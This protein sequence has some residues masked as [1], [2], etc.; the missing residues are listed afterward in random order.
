L[1]VETSFELV[2]ELIGVDAVIVGPAGAAEITLILDTA[3]VM[4]TIVPSVAESV[5]L[6]AALREGWSVT[7][8]AAAEERGYVTRSEPSAL[9]FTTP[10]HRVVVADL[11]YGIDGLLGINFLRDFN[12]EIRFADRR[13]LVEKILASE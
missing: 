8:T 3:A 10:N 7:R 2:G 9:G 13:I 1:K 5:G 6:S 11:G 12:V 4:T